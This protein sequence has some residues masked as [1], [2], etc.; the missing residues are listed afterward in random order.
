MFCCCWTSA[1][2]NH[3]EVKQSAMAQGL[4]IRP[5]DLG[6]AMVPLTDPRHNHAGRQSTTLQTVSVHA[7]CH[8]S[9]QIKLFHPFIYV[10]QVHNLLFNFACFY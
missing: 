5:P 9:I 6:S 2:V 4:P 7:D 8:T 1:G 10:Y 3:A